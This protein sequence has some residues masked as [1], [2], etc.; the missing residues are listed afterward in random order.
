M[1]G[2]HVAFKTFDNRPPV[3]SGS[4]EFERVRDRQIYGFNELFDTEI[5]FNLNRF[6]RSL[7]QWR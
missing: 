4:Q 2:E 1:G 5:V 7:K 3:M 6:E